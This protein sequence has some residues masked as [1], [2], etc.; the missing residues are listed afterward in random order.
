V[1]GLT[2]PDGGAEGFA[3]SERPER[4]RVAAVE[5]L[6]PPAKRGGRKRSIYRTVPGQPNFIAEFSNWNFSVAPTDADFTFQ[7]PEGAKQVELKAAAAP[8][9]KA[10]GATR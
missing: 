5:P 7:P 9:A 2:S 10:K 6:I 8:P 3:L 1:D 4:G